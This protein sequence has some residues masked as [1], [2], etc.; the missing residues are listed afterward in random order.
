MKR[1]AIPIIAATGLVLA[2]LIGYFILYRTCTEKYDSGAFMRFHTD[3]FGKSLYYI[4]LPM[5][6]ICNVNYGF[7]LDFGS[8]H[9]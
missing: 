1:F 9:P 6:K 2:Y 8:F 5:N 7:Y 3:L 4:Y